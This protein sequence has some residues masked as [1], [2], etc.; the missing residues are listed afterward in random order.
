MDSQSTPLNRSVSLKQLMEGFDKLTKHVAKSSS[1][2]D[3]TDVENTSEKSPRM[4]QGRVDNSTSSIEKSE[5]CDV[6]SDADSASEEQP[7]EQASI[8]RSTSLIITPASTPLSEVTLRE[9]RNS[10]DPSRMDGPPAVL[11]VRGQ[12]FQEPAVVPATK[13]RLLRKLRNS[14]GRVTSNVLKSP[15]SDSA[16]IAMPPSTPGEWARQIVAHLT[17]QNA[18]QLGI[19]LQEKRKALQPEGADRLRVADSL[20]DFLIDELAA[21]DDPALK[22]VINGIPIGLSLRDELEVLCGELEGRCRFAT[23]D[24]IIDTS[25]EAISREI[26]RLY[27][28]HFTENGPE[29]VALPSGLADL[30]IYFPPWF[31][32]SFGYASCRLKHYGDESEWLI[33]PSV[34]KKNPAEANETKRKALRRLREFVGSGHDGLLCWTVGE[35]LGP[36]FHS[37]VT[38]VLFDRLSKEKSRV[39]ELHR[40]TGQAIKPVS[41]ASIDFLL[42]KTSSG[43][44]VIEYTARISRDSCGG[45]APQA[46]LLEDPATLFTADDEA[47]LQIFAK[48]TVHSSRDIEIDA[49]RLVAQGWNG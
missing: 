24:R 42:E 43:A 27:V 22:A 35:H 23:I 20:R 12:G 10:W 7:G 15:K 26:D 8:V 17:L 2:A 21:M 30:S 11:H 3:K 19:L 16:L 14:I 31:V 34:L 44:V 49:I 37:F 4:T 36:D 41:P 1:I 46:R 32:G 28:F 45:S 29:A 5:D 40:Y 39:S 13:R 33:D 9:R 6:L 38:D 47:L 25:H 48:V 18:R